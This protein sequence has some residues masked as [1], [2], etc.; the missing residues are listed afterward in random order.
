MQNI[1]NYLLR[2]SQNIQEKMSD[3]ITTTLYGN[4]HATKRIFNKDFVADMS[5]DQS[6]AVYNSRFANAADFQFFIVGEVTKENLKPLL[7]EY[8]ASIPTTKEK[9]NWKDNSVEW[10]EKNVDKDI[11]L[12]T[13]GA[14][15]IIS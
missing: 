1:D 11:Y 12:Y 4:N 6:K 13:K 9:E 3:S 10:S 8:I 5:F 2:R 7:V 15:N 14:D